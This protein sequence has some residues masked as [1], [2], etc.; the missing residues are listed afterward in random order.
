M[1]MKVSIAIPTPL[2]GYVDNQDIVLI[3]GGDNV[4]LALKLLIKQYPALKEHL[5]NEENELRKFVNFYVNEEDI[6]HLDNENTLLKE[7]DEL[8]IVPSIAGGVIL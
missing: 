8:M 2:R 3:N 1:I 5:Y 6:R 7:G 4:K